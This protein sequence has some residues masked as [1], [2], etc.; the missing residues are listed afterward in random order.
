LPLSVVRFS[1]A[2]RYLTSIAH[3]TL[4]ISEQLLNIEW[5]LPFN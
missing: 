4:C 5:T 1:F 3:L 2:E